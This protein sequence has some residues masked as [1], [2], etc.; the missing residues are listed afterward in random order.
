MMNLLL[1]YIKY[2]LWEG[3]L[4]GWGKRKQKGLTFHYI[5]TLYIL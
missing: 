5:Y 1:L 3:D 2:C 4:G